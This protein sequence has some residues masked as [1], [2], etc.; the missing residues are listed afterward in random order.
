M[1]GPGE[2]KDDGGVGGR[3]FILAAK[4]LV[5]AG[6]SQPGQREPALVVIDLSDWT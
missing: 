1:W 4:T 3:D 2:A 5:D 6:S